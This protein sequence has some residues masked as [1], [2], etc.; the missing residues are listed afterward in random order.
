MA[1]AEQKPVIGV[2]AETIRLRLKGTEA[3]C[4]IIVETLDNQWTLLV[5]SS[6]DGRG[7]GA[8]KRYYQCKILDGPR[9]GKIISVC[10]D[11]IVLQVGNI[12]QV[13]ARDMLQGVATVT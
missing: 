7:G 4:H 8:G 3:D 6:W 11:H 9:A 12:E 2:L 13:P 5:L 1:K 10:G